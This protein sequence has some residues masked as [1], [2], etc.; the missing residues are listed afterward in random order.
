MIPHNLIQ[1]SF[2]QNPLNFSPKIMVI[3][4]GS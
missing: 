3:Y 2:V 1:I 4:L